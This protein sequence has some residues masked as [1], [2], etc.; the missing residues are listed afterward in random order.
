M[1]NTRKSSQH[2][3]CG[4]FISS[5]TRS[6]VKSSPADEP[7]HKDPGSDVSSSSAR[8]SPPS[9]RTRCRT[10]PSSSDTSPGPQVKGQR[11]TWNIPSQHSRLSTET[12]Q[13]GHGSISRKSQR[14]E[15]SADA[16][17]NG[18]VELKR[19]C[20]SRKSR[21][22]HLNQSRLFDQLVNSTA[23]AVLQE[24]DNISSIRQ[25][26][27]V[28]RLRMWT[29][30]ELENMDMYSRVKRRRKSL[31]RNAYGMQTHHKVLSKGEEEEEEGT[32]ESHEEEEE[33][34]DDEVEDDDEDDEDD[35]GDE[36]EEAGEENDRPYNLR[37]RKTVQR[38]EAP[39]IG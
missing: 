16:R 5:R 19:S 7:L 17:M 13:N 38:Y 3:S 22:E 14:G 9:K 10:T 6:S 1:V 12:L 37:Q 30:T 18:H 15:D 24:M 39:P 25:N 36:A 35:E 11:V 27:E 8:L 26:R 31:R 34:D 33:D 23:E 2:E 29:D 20:R 4:L 32:E 21:F 28:E